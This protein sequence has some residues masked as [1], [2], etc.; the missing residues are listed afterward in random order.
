MKNSK[1]LPRDVS[2]R[3]RALYASSR[4]CCFRRVPR[5]AS[6]DI[7]GRAR[8]RARERR[9]GANKSLS[10]CSVKKREVARYM[11]PDKGGVRDHGGRENERLLSLSIYT[12][13]AAYFVLSFCRRRA[14]RRPADKTEPRAQPSCKIAKI[15]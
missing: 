13:R 15:L 1:G 3:A 10:N 14:D 9:A 11:A 7:G 6:V 4:L 5:R 2:Q 8:S 12:E